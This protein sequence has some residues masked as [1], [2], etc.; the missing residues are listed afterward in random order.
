VGIKAD[1][2][3]RGEMRLSFDI[4]RATWDAELRRYPAA[5]QQD[6]NYGEALVELGADV[7]RVSIDDD[8]GRL[9][10]A[11]IT[12][13][14]FAGLV[15]LAVCTRGPVWL[16][17]L[18]AGQKGQVIK[19]IKRSLGLSWPRITLVTPDDVV[20]PAGL[21]RVMT[22]YSTVLLDLNQDLTTLRAGFDGKWRNRLNAA[23]KS[24]LK[25]AQ[26]SVKLA[27]Y[28]W[29][30]QTE[31]G[32]REERGYKATPAAIVPAFQTATGDRDSLLI[33]R[34]DQGREKIAAMMFLIHGCSATYHIGWNSETGRKLGA[35]N[36]LLWQA[37]DELKNRGVVQLDLGGVNTTRGAGLARFK[38]GT[39]GQVVTYCGTYF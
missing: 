5:L 26:N 14:K 27:Q 20:P 21:F 4:D 38:I 8:Q 16:R 9:A 24:G 39:G 13:R 7:R 12:V 28:R 11:Q 35:H 19:L 33:L 2:S 31:E 23:E 32:Q 34:A 22:G 29:L 25:S 30:L 36:L 3:L 18:D 17:E 1:S 15:T 10:L 6:W 37:L